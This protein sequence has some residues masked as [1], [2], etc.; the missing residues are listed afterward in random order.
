MVEQLCLVN[1]A[2]SSE[3]TIIHPEGDKIKVAQNDALTLTCRGGAAG[4]VRWLHKGVPLTSEGRV[5]IAY[6]PS[7]DD[8][9]QSTLT[10]DDVTATDAGSYR[11]EEVDNIFN[12]DS[13]EVIVTSSEG[14]VVNMLAVGFAYLIKP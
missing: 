12:V 8:V 2:P 11:C 10:V 1:S 13:I 7:G 4:G 5:N 9:W 6:T 14:E 3:L